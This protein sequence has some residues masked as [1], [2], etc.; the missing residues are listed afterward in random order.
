MISVIRICLIFH[1]CVVFYDLSIFTGFSSFYNPHHAWEISDY[2][3]VDV[4]KVTQ[5]V[6]DG[7]GLETQ[8]IQHSCSNSNTSVWKGILCMFCFSTISHT[9]PSNPAPAPRCRSKNTFLLFFIA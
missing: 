5:G 7:V 4:A 3:R 6:K 8:D 9:P 2:F 1:D